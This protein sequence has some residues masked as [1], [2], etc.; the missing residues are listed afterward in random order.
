MITKATP[1]LLAATL[2]TLSGCATRP[3][4]ASQ[5]RFPIDSGNIEAGR[6]AFIALQCHQCHTV[7]GV[8]LPAYRG[9]SPLKLEL[10]GEI[11]YA[12]TYAGLV[13]SIINPSHVLS[14]RYLKMLP[15]DKQGGARSIM[16]FRKDMTVEQLVDGVTFLNS[17]YVKIEG[18]KETFYR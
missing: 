16:P 11:I 10:G 1:C 8:D 7:S 5:F 9:T 18:Y 3:D 17:R 4:Y 13:T 2:L 6:A 12:K 15:A 14:E